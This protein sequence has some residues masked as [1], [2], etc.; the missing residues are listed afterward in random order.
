M[1]K[2]REP[3]P[4]GSGIFCHYHQ[5]CTCSY[6]SGFLRERCKETN[7]WAD[8][9]AVLTLGGSSPYLFIL[10]HTYFKIKALLTMG[11]ILSVPLFCAQKL[12]IEMFLHPLHCACI[13]TSAMLKDLISMCKC[14]DGSVLQEKLEADC[15]RLKIL[16]LF[17]CHLPLLEWKLCLH[18]TFFC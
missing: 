10:S 6:D 11:H 4:I 14:G 8:V 3:L 18:F 1:K 2:L 13:L 15:C 17:E 12:C 5:T 16:A 7:K 9:L